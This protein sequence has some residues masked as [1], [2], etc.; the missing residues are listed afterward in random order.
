MFIELFSNYPNQYLCPKTIVIN[1]TCIVKLF[2][3]NLWNDLLIFLLK[4]Q[5]QTNMIDG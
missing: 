4:L 2:V 1:K 3:D 5:V